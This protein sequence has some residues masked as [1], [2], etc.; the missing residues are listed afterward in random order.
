MAVAK[1]TKSV[2]PVVK[3]KKLN[4]KAKL[5]QQ[6]TEGSAGLDLCVLEDVAIR[7]TTATDVAY[8]VRTG[9]AVAIPEG[10]VGKIYLRSSTG[11]K[12]KLRLA[13][14]T[15]IIDSDYRGEVMVLLENVGAMTQYVSEGERLFQM[16]IEKQEQIKFEQVDKLDETQRGTGGMGSTGSK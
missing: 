15:G 8:K 5:P 10:Y 1:T 13:N 6:M 2:L 11:A 3:I 4:E 16:L 12:T 7:P 14:G 9:L